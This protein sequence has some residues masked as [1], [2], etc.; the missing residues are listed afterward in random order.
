MTTQTKQLP[1]R[2]REWVNEGCP[3]ETG[4]GYRNVGEVI[5]AIADKIERTTLPLPVDKKGEPWKVGDACVIYSS[6]GETDGEITGY[7]IREN[8]TRL[9]IVTEYGETYL[10][11]TFIRRPTADTNGES[12]KVDDA[13]Y[14]ILDN[15]EEPY[16]TRYTVVRLEPD[17]ELPVVCESSKGCGNLHFR[18]DGQSLSHRAPDSYEKL[19]DDMESWNNTR[20]QHHVDVWSERLT[21]LIERGQ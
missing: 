9:L 6:I 18:F 13:V 21:A 17:S 7:I 16:G 1:E 5:R 12:I 14:S 15:G 4:C 11:A 8:D 10:P 19:R 3:I 2:L 20:C